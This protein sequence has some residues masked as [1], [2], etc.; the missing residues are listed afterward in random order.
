M[1]RGPSHSTSRKLCSA[2]R[3]TPLKLERLETRLLMAFDTLVPE[4]NQF[5]L[6]EASSG[7]RVE[8]TV[9]SNDQRLARIALI[10]PDGKAI[11]AGSRVEQLDSRLQVK[12][13]GLNAQGH[14]L[15]GT[16]RTRWIVSSPDRQA[17]AT[18]QIAD[19]RA[20]LSFDR[21]ADYQITVKSGRVSTR[22]HVRILASATSISVMDERNSQ[23]IADNGLIRT[24]ERSH[25]FSVAGQSAM[26][27]AAALTGETQWSVL[28]SPNGSSPQFQTQG[29]R[30]T[31][32]FD[33]AGRYTFLMRNGSLFSRVRV[34][35]NADLTSLA[36]NTPAS[37]V[38]QG[39][40]LQFQAVGLDQFKQ[41]M[42]IQPI[43]TWK[44]TGGTISSSGL[45]QAAA[46]AGSFQVT[47]QSGR[48]TAEAAITVTAANSTDAPSADSGSGV[49]IVG[50]HDV[51]LRSLMQS[52][53]A[54]GSINRSEMIE[55]LR[56]AA[57]DRIVTTTELSD[58][59]YIASDRA[60]FSMP[61]HVRG[62][63]QNVL[64]DNP[65]NLRFRNHTA[66]NLT[67]GSSGT[68]L[69]QL[70][71]KW[72]LGADL[73]SLT[74]STVS[75]RYAVGALFNGSPGLTDSRQG[76]LGDCYFLASLVSIAQINPRAIE[77]MFIDNGDGTFT[78]RFFSGNLG[79]FWQGSLISA[80]F[81]S[82]SG[83]AD[84]VTVDRYLPTFS[85]GGLAYSGYGLS[86]LRSTTSVWLALAEKAYAQWNE[87]GR[88][89]RD[90]T[91]TYAG[92]EG[93]WMSNS[94][95]YAVNSGS[96]RA[97]IDALKAGHAVTMGTNPRA[98]TGGLVGAHAYVVTAYNASS[99]TFSF[100][101]TWSTRHPTPLTW[102]QMQGQISAFVIANASGSLHSGQGSVRSTDRP[103][104]APAVQATVKSALQIAPEQIDRLLD[105]LVSEEDSAHNPSLLQSGQV[106]ADVGD[107]QPEYL[108]YTESPSDDLE[109]RDPLYEAGELIDQLIGS[110]ELF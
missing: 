37:S 73:P 14:L 21:A 79:M 51:G 45:F 68:L 39:Q 41:A 20:T 11:Q 32:R 23:R 29:T 47:V 26:R 35:V 34:Q 105:L 12:T 63:A 96:K 55:L 93:G 95:F 75:Y 77:N 92:I 57:T 46:N 104:A 48:L 85:N 60:S 87:T 82:G 25:S 84:Y 33:R 1:N 62:L 70:V 8:S 2:T 99:D 4:G 52:A 64:H 108:L 90:G 16:P 10:L 28:S 13:Q 107:Y 88:S 42:S 72:F 19:D 24:S 6:P 59:R 91:N 36:V 50:V 110:L 22:F 103:L 69:N 101:N 102:A 74:A 49:N 65:A 98:S 106:V 5:L 30:T 78:V 86:A 66:G 67:A 71:D 53:Y 27:A 100:Y 56:S 38:Q 89:G 9:R 40:S 97:M 83:V 44:A 18:I 80:G 61:D 15:D 31:V 54:D 43:F 17:R 109:E 76:A 81:V 3:S 94:T 7:W 58:L